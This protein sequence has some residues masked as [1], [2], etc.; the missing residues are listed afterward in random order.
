ML[1]NAARDLAR[2]LA[3]FVHASPTPYHAVAEA[4][5]RLEAAGFSKVQETQPWPIQAGARHFLIRGGGSLVAYVVG[6]T[7]PA[8][9]GFT[10]IG[11]HTDSPNLR[12]KVRAALEKKG[13]GMLAIETYGG[14]LLHTWLDRDLGIAGRVAVAST[15]DPRGYSLHNV[16]IDKPVARVSSLA[17]HLDRDVNSKG[18]KLNKQTHMPAMFSLAESD[19]QAEEH[20][21]HLIHE[22][23]GASAGPLLSHDLS[24]FDL[25]APTLG[26]AHGE[27]LF[28]PRLD[29]LASAHAS[30]TALIGAASVAREQ[31]RVIALFDNEEVGSVS[32]RGAASGLLSDVLTRLVEG[33][34]D[35]HGS[36]LHRAV[37]RSLCISAD[38]AHAVH[39]NYA[40]MHDDRHGPRLG[41]GPVLKT[42][43]NLRYATSIDTA[44]R[45]RAICRRAE[46]PVQDFINRSDLGCG[47][48]I[49]PITA[50]ELGIPTVDV[51][52][53]MLSMHSSR[54]MAATADVPLMIRA[55]EAA[56]GRRG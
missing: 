34:S 28:S 43:A 35:G 30:V 6:G 46:V 16:R 25:A 10:I 9:A 31:T 18:L 44:A 22:A 50:A 39:P 11:S 3:S 56:L 33:F 5:S 8:K 40:D 26:G 4:A 42:N 53:P 23:L 29:N 24:L 13:S 54:E 51:G 52:N 17:I 37:A 7:P 47:S 49:G 20:L 27:L 21:R 12:L 19:E 55:L 48:T 36:G 1:D 15:S 32:D 45:F 38:M 41:K 14:V 2:D